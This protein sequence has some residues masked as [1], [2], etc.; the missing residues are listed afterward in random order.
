M[1]TKDVTDEEIAS[2]TGLKINIVRKVLYDMF[3]KALITGIVSRTKRKVG[4]STAGAPSR[5][6][7]TISLTIR[8]KR[9]L[10]GSTIVLNMKNQQ[11]F[12]TVATVIVRG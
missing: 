3:G 10:T 12:T 2:A 8:R 9:S 4:S 5:I 1:N 6:R 11:S 7:S